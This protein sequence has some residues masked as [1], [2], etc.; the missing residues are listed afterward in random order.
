MYGDFDFFAGK[1]SFLEFLI[2]R[3]KTIEISWKLIPD[4]NLEITIKIGRSV[5]MQ[6][7]YRK[8]GNS[9]GKRN[10]CF[11]I[12]K[13][14]LFRRECIFLKWR[15]ELKEFWKIIHFAVRLFRERG[16]VIT[17]YRV[18]CTYITLILEISL[19]EMSA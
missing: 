3:W 6:I 15:M 8:T 9:W 18:T 12:F 2:S 1:R 19:F 5:Y 11:C 17:E 14:I 16:L 10:T 7:K 4:F 13:R